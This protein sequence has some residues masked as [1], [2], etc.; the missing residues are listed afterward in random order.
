[1]DKDSI[2]GL[3]LA[4]GIPTDETISE[5]LNPNYDFYRHSNISEAKRCIPLLN[6]LM[7][8]ISELRAEWP[9][10]PTLNQVLITLCSIELLL[11]II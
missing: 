10:H 6:D 11:S 1:L 7:I 9:D 8:R 3:Y 5:V 4:T 2:T